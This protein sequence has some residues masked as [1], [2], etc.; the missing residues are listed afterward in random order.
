MEGVALR[1]ALVA[2]SLRRAFPNATEIRASGGALGKS[3]VWAQMI[4]DAIGQ[5]L[6]L[7]AESEASSRGAALVAL[8]AAGFPVDDNQTPAQTGRVLQPNPTRHER[9]QEALAAQQNLYAR[10]AD[11]EG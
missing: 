4:C 9:Y 6:N 5:P 7:I 1:F 11:R 8:A 10:L 2:E 3:V